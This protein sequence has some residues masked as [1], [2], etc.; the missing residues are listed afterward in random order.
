VLVLVACFAGC[1]ERERERSQPVQVPKPKA[2]VAAAQ[3]ATTRSVPRRDWPCRISGKGS[4]GSAVEITIR[5]ADRETC[6]LPVEKHAVGI[7]G[8]ALELVGEIRD[9]NGLVNHATERFSYMGET[10]G[11][12]APAV[13][14]WENGLVVGHGTG[15]ILEAPYELTPRGVKF[16]RGTITVD[17]VIVDGKLVA[18]DDSTGDQTERFKL[19]WAGDRLLRIDKVRTSPAITIELLLAYDCEPDAR[20]L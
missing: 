6:T 19:T 4:D 16:K 7:T 3:R 14:V 9:A 20:K 1:K 17:M 10:F 13:L 12:S 11:D 18:R 8:C 15:S 5:Y 2:D